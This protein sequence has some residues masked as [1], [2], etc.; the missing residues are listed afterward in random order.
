MKM[1]HLHSEIQ[2][3]IL[4]YLSVHPRASAPVEN[5]CSNWLANESVSHNIDQVQTA[6]DRLVAHGEVHKRQ[7]SD[8]YTL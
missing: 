5:I 1:S 8:L 7:D 3:G 6:L 4:N 2:T